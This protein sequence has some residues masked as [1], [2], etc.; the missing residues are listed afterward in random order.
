MPSASLWASVPHYV[1]AAPNPKAALALVRKLEAPRRR[2][3]RRRGAR[4]RRRRLRAPGVAGR[5]ERPGRRRPSSSA[6]RPP[7]RRRSRSCARRTCPP[8]T[9]SPA[10]SSASCASA[11]RA[12]TD[13]AGRPRRAR[14]APG[15]RR[16]RR[17]RGGGGRAPGPGGR[18]RRR[19]GGA[20]GAAPD[21][22][23]AG[24][25]HRRRRVLRPG[26]PRRSGRLRPAPAERAARAP[27]RRAPAA[28][29]RGDRPLHR[30]RGDRG[31]A[32][33][34][35]PGRAR[36]GV[37]RRRA[38]GR[39][40]AW[41]TAWRPHRRPLRAAARPSWSGASTSWSGSCPTCRR[42]SWACCS[43]TRWPSSRR[44]PTTAGP[45]APRPAA[46]AGR[47]A[48]R[49]CG[50]AAR[51]CSSSAARRP[52]R[53]RG[54]LARHGYA[55]VARA[56]RRGR[57]R[58]RPRGDARAGL[59]RARRAPDPGPALVLVDQRRLGVRDRGV[60]RQVVD[61]EL[62]QVLGV[63]RGDPDEVVGRARRGGRRMS[64]PGSPR[65][66]RVKVSICSRAWTARRTATIACS[67][68]P[69]AARSTSAWKPRT[70]P[71]RAQRAD[72]RSARGGRDAGA[73]GQAR[74]GHA[75]VLGQRLEDR[76]VD[77]VQVDCSRAAG[78][79]GMTVDHTR[80]AAVV[81]SRA[82]IGR[83]SAAPCHR[84]RTGA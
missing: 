37:R 18:R 13:D 81:R 12:R 63:A 58:P 71:R 21:R 38:R 50:P 4:A 84:R 77:V 60:G 17:G 2:L 74:V 34:A 43:A 32:G 27:R 83:T 15:R 35:P 46:R 72:P 11:G 36:R 67:G 10:S 41:R 40:R 44:G 69:S 26:G 20:R 8:A 68:R 64:T 52:T 7:P 45:T 31:D 48:A 24:L 33:R 29:R 70:T 55:G 51:S 22:R 66:W 6:S 65:T 75:R 76:A 73:L 61:D 16:V 82:R 54:D 28:R 1:A 30:R 5:A 80:C 3:G 39:L 25:D 57:R 14:G 9:S 79:F 53:S 19:P 56:R 62:A 49:S 59:G 47:G 78:S 23:A 42:R